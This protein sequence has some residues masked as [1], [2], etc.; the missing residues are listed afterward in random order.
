M[1]RHVLDHFATYD[2]EDRL[3]F[4]D[5]EYEAKPYG[6][7][8]E[9]IEAGLKTECEWNIKRLVDDVW[10]C[11]HAEAF[12]GE[13]PYSIEEYIERCRAAAGQ[14]VPDPHKAFVWYFQ[15]GPLVTFYETK[16]RIVSGPL[17]V[18]GRFLISWN[19]GP[20]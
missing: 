19:Y 16:E 1:V 3:V 9:A 12:C 11:D 14:Q 5:T 4:N 17:T 7:V 10:D 20:R 18:S 15:E 8:V 2:S 6:H 13:D